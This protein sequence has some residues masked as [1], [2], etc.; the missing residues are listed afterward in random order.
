MATERDVEVLSIVP[1][2]G[3]EEGR[4]CEERPERLQERGGEGVERG[5]GEG[6]GG[7]GW[8]VVGQ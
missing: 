6:T 3:E 2:G 7:E 5:R 1:A 8:G 4:V